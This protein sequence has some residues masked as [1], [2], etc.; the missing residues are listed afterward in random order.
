MA[1]TN[2]ESKKEIGRIEIE[3]LND[4]NF[5]YKVYPKE[6]RNSNMPMFMMDTYAFTSIDQVKNAIEDDFGSPQKISTDKEDNEE[7]YEEEYDDSNFRKK[8]RFKKPMMKGKGRI[9]E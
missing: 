3:R 5:I 9:F 6:K 4:G 8:D 1:H 7:D 2:K